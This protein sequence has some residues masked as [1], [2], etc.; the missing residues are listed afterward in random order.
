MR[1]HSLKLSSVIKCYDLPF[2]DLSERYTACTIYL[3]LTSYGM[4]QHFQMHHSTCSCSRQVYGPSMLP[5]FSTNTEWII[6]VA[7]SV[8]LGRPLARSELVV[9]DSPREPNGQICK[10]VIGLPG[11]VVCVDP[12]G[13]RGMSTEHCL[14][15]KGHIWIAGDNAAASRDSRDYG[16]VPVALVR[17]RVF[18]RV[19]SFVNTFLRNN[20]LVPLDRALEITS[21]LSQ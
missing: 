2:S 20:L 7:L 13:E 10:R 3:E 6:E 15:P 8:R 4:S 16:P 9:L 17:S 5:T 12:S 18:A 19:C 21:Y 14:I 1:N 11:D